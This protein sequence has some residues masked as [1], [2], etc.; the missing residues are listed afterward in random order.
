ML[1]WIVLGV[2]FGG[3]THFFDNQDAKGGL[4]GSLLV[5]VVGALSGG[6]VAAFLFGFSSQFDVSA[7]LIALTGTLLLLLFH[8]T[9]FSKQER[10]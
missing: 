4:V 6:L 3:L 8:R 5:G 1:L 9:I 10:F 2:V 7:L